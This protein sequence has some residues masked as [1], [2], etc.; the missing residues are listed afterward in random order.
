[1]FIRRIWN[2]ASIPT[3]PPFTCAHGFQ[4]EYRLRRADGEYRWVL[5][6]GVP[7]FEKGDI[8]VGY[9]G[10]CIDITDLKRTQQEHLA[11][12]KLESV[13]TMARG[14]A[15]DFNNLLGGIL[16]HSDLALAELTD[17]SGPVEELQ[18]IRTAAI[19][20]AEIV[21]QLMIYAGREREVL[22]LVDVSE[23]VRDMLELL[24]VSVSKHAVVETDSWQ[25]PSGRASQL[26]T[27]APSC[28]ESD[29]QCVGSHRRSGRSDP[30]D[31]GVGN[32]KARLA[33]RGLG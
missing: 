26:G 25:G 23:I 9:I 17:G 22:E 10:S 21:R 31:H 28:N 2:A 15:H 5:D 33:C 20:G 1:M 29:Y 32:S 14:I 3:H 27:T 18:R 4:M 12:Q 11:K 16:A 19:R 30:R 6:N 8:F 13:G 24:K 7:R